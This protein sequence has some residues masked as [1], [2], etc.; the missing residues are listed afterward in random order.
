MRVIPDPGDGRPWV[1][2]LWT[3]GALAALAFMSFVLL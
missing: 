2:L 3:L 1:W